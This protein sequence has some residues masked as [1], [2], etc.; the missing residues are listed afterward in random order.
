MSYLY[1]RYLTLYQDN[2]QTI[3]HLV[4]MNMN[5]MIDM[6]NL[7]VTDMV[8]IGDLKDMTDDKHL[9]SK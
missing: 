7:S 1:T 9:I 3:G 4:Y 6:S 5:D 2:T 8:D